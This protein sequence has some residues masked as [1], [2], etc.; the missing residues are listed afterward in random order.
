ME[1][2]ESGPCEILEWDTKF[3]GFRIGR[4]RDHELTLAL[5][6]QIDAWCAQNRVSCLYFLAPAADG[7]TTSIAEDNGFHL[8]DIRITFEHRD[9]GLI[10]GIHEPVHTFPI[11]M[12]RLQDV[13]HLAAI[14]KQS[15]YDS[16]F[17]FDHNFPRDMS[18]AL[19]ETWITQSCSGYADAVLVAEFDHTPVGYISCHR[20]R[21]E[22][23]G[24]IGLVGVSHQVQGRGVGQTLVLR[25]LEWF[26]K[27]GTQV[28]TVVTQGRNC[29]AQRLYQRCGF[30]TQTVQLWYHK[31]Y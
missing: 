11:R 5:V 2:D 20:D 3:F 30:L 14:A 6:R 29:A 1:S 21:G 31:W 4:V 22:N 15:Y 18:E 8:V 9:P 23:K 28:V 19:Y 17:F 12:A 16:R 24:E 7:P 26:A 10:N 27:Q 25:A 13:E